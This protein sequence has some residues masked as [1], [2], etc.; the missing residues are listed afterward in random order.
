M[1]KTE[2]RYQ[3][4]PSSRLRLATL[5]YIPTHVQLSV[6]ECRNMTLHRTYRP[7]GQEKIIHLRMGEWSHF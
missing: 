3:C 4:D 5:P 2:W 7:Q 6:E 1:M